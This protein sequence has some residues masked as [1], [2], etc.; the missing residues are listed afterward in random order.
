[1][2]SFLT[3]VSRKVNYRLCKTVQ[4]DKGLKNTVEPWLIGSQLF[5]I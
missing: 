5:E 1:M 4:G 3:A 2:D